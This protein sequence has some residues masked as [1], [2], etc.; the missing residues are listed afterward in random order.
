MVLID[1]SVWI[2]YFRGKISNGFLVRKLLRERR[3]LSHPWVLGELMMGYM[4][5]QR[6]KV[7]SDLQWL[8]QL[9]V[10]NVSFL[11]DFVE[12]EKLYGLGLSLV[13]VQLLY[14]AWLYPCKILTS[15]KAFGRIAK[16]HDIA[17]DCLN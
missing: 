13:D 17:F 12:R 2:D 14:G 11:R 10:Y 1:T 4:G 7:L 8:P 5:P 6:R 9:I 16:R 15:D 3:V